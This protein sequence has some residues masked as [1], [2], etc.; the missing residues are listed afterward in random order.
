[1]L[2]APSDLVCSLEKTLGMESEGWDWSQKD[3]IAL[4]EGGNLLLDGVGGTMKLLLW[5]P[6]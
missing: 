4:A 6:F 1:M 3:G 5:F 2:M